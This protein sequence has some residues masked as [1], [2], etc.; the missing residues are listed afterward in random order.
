MCKFST[1]NIYVGNIPIE[2]TA[3]ELRTEFDP[4][5]QIMSIKVMNDKYIGSGQEH[6]Y[7]F[8]EM[9]S[10][11]EAAVAV[12]S[13]NGKNIKGQVIEVIEALPLSIDDSNEYSNSKKRNRYY[14]RRHRKY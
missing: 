6:G 7:A 11:P 10:T 1:M 13:L 9:A 14:K 4:F 2:M 3:D 5:G 8:V 12:T